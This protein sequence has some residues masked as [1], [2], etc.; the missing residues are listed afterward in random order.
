MTGERGTAATMS[1][2]LPLYNEAEGIA[3]IVANL[4]NALEREAIPYQLVLVNNGSTDG[5]ATILA[6]IASQNPAVHVTTVPV[7]QGYGWGII[8]GLKEATGEIV[9]FMCADGQIAPADV[10][11]VYRRL[12]DGDV[13]LSKVVRVTREDG[14]TRRVMSVVYNR[15]FRVLFAFKAADINGTPKLMWRARFAELELSSKDWFIDAELMIRAVERGF[16][17]AEVAVNFAARNHGASNVRLTTS[18]EFLRN[19]F[20]YRFAR[21]RRS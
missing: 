13:D 10:I 3:A 7:N 2:V 1:L 12:V 20:R 16:R 14:F 18:L 19:M 15:L 6:E 5:S 8:C 9:G 4:T 11:H 21:G 17:I